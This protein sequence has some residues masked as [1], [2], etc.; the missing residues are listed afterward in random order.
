MAKEVATRTALHVIV[1]ERGPARNISQYA[2]GMDEINSRRVGLVQ[3]P[4]DQTIT[5]RHSLKDPAA[6]IRQY[7]AFRPG[8]GTGGTSEHWGGISDRYLPDFFVLATHLR[9]KFGA[10]RMSQD[11]TIQDWGITYDEFENY[12]WRAEQLM[13]ISGKAGNLRGDSVGLSSFSAA[14]RQPEP[15]LYQSR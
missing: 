10:S 9:E 12:Y 5:H 4:A 6:P 1:L 8:T 11:W 3:N 15:G 7:G 14:R 13:G 2:S